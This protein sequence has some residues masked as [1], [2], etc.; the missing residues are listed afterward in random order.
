MSSSSS[1]SSST[2]SSAS[3]SPLFRLHTPWYSN[4]GQ[5]AI[6]V[7][8]ESGAAYSVATVN[9]FTS[10]PLSSAYKSTNPLGVVPALELLDGSGRTLGESRPIAKYLAENF[11]A[12]SLYPSGPSGW[13]RALIDQWVSFE[14][15]N[16]TP[17]IF[18]VLDNTAFAEV[19]GRQPDQE[20][21]QAAVKRLAAYLNYL[22]AALK[23]RR[24]LVNDALSLADLNFAP[25]LFNLSQT[26][27]A[28]LISQ[29]ERPNVAAWVDR[30]RSRPSWQKVAKKAAEEMPA[31]VAEA[32]KNGEKLDIRVI[33][34]LPRNVSKTKDVPVEAKI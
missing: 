18:D 5:K 12:A 4:H 7:A 20:K 29:A 17:L 14:Q 10:G 9:F 34:G 31:H 2:S 24:Y 11:A 21:L 3:S 23:G 27:Y 8:E 15:E 28:S 1:S 16:T 26:P 19:S 22:E 30:V 6:L 32:T 13:T 25:E 33:G